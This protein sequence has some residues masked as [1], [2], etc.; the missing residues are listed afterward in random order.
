MAQRYAELHPDGD[1]T[2]L[3]AFVE[4]QYRLLREGRTSRSDVDEWLREELLSAAK[5][6][7][8]ARQRQN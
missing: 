7:W 8:R 6:H 2:G 5:E 4:E 1:E 3:V